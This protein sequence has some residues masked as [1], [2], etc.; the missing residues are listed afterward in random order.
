MLIPILLIA[1]LIA[2]LTSLIFRANLKVS[3]TSSLISAG[4]QLAISLFIV[5]T[6]AQTK[7]YGFAPYFE[8]DSLAA[9]LTIITS[10]VGFG[11]VA[12]NI[13]FVRAEM[14]KKIIGL[15]RARQSYFLINLFLLAMF[16]AITTTN[17]IITWISIEATTLSTVFLISFYNKPTAIEAAWKYLV[18]N[19]VGLML[20]FLGTVIYLSLA[21]PFIRSDFI[22]WQ[23]ILLAAP[24][25][26]PDVIKMAFIFLLIGYGTKVG[27]APM[28][29]WL[30]DAHS[31]APSPISAILSGALLNIAL[32]PILRFKMVTDITVG[33]SFTQNLFIFFGTISIILA[34]FAIFRQESYKRLLAYS[35]IEHEAVILLGFGFGGLGVYAGLLHMVYHSLAK[36]AMFLLS[37]NILLKYDSSK[38]KNVAN[39]IGL[40]PKT[41]VLFIIGF[42]ALTA[43][44]PFGI[45]LTEFY[46]ILAGIQTHP[47]VA[48][49][50]VFA[51]ALIFFGFFRQVTSMMFGKS[52]NPSNVNV[53]EYG[54][55]TLLPPVV[56]L[57]ILI[58]LSLMLPDLLATILNDA[59]LLF[60]K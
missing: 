34:A 30:P 50:I 19:S 40:L 49:V 24:N 18:I 6:I 1:P 59:A 27:L 57:G 15:S 17:P 46:I 37:G 42:L 35:S 41:G 56:L 22:T 3:E 2:I 45:F 51:L 54:N 29:S 8:I 28:H 21:T 14:S 31:Q 10:I 25:L 38:I 33:S 23:N 7:S 44:P 11:A 39:V 47:W 55:W 58:F 9:I 5:A 4:I 52:T 26:D 12:Y 20:A 60:N 36:S 16:L 48:T 32:L 53:A 13:G 43:V